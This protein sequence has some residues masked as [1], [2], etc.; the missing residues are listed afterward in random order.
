MGVTPGPFRVNIWADRL[1]LHAGECTTLHW[2]IDQATS[3]TL[4]G[5]SVAA[6]GSRQVCPAVSTRYRF[7]ITAPSG[8]TDRDIMITVAAPSDTTPPT[9]SG[10][11]AS[12]SQ[13]YV[14]NCQP[15]TAVITANATDASAISRVELTYRVVE[16]SRQ[17]AWRTLTMSSA[18]GSSYRA[19]LD[20]AAL[21]SSLH[22]PVTTGATIQYYVR[23]QDARGNAAQ[24]S[25]FTITYEECII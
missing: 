1:D 10:V 3:V 20:W 17:G 25:T 2:E 12:A 9:I 14:P 6:Y 21:D 24:S 18:G 8:G 4:D 16:G 5:G 15:N 22:P 11:M 7:H 19:T 23:A 13:I